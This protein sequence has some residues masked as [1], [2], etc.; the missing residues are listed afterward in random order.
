MAKLILI[1]EDE[2][3]LR[4]MYQQRFQQEGF[5][6]ETA[7]DGEEGLIQ[8]KKVQP[9]LILLDILMPKE[10]G[11]VLLKNIR[12]VSEIAQTKVVAFSNF[13]DPSSKSMA[14]ELGVVDY[15][16]KTNYTPG[17]VVA[18]IKNHLV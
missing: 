11:L 7:S 10:N 13:D 16:I 2:P 6:V 17:E 18:K 14:T 1:V 9:D 8:V 3:I 15:L 12:A 5:R 4:E